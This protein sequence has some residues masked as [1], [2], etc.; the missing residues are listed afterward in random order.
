MTMK[1]F[2]YFIGRGQLQAIAA[3]FMTI[4]IYNTGYVTAKNGMPMDF[5]SIS[6]VTYTA[7]ILSQ[8]ATIIVESHTITK[9]NHYAIWGMVV[10]YIVSILCYSALYIPG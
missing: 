7:L 5:D 6:T 1:S 10:F 2:A 3:L 9:I 4:G 8:T